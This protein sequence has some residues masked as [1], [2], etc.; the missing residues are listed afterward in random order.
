[1]PERREMI[2]FVNIQFMHFCFHCDDSCYLIYI[3]AII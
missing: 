2:L 1:M 3:N